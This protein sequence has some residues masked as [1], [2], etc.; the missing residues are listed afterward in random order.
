MTRDT[1][2]IDVIDDEAGEA[3]DE[4]EFA[5]WWAQLPDF[6]KPDYPFDM[7]PARLPFVQ[8]VFTQMGAPRHCPEARCRRSGQCRGGDGPPCLRA[9]PKDL[10][11]VLFLVYMMLFAD[12][13]EQELWRTL[14]AQG[15]RY[16][17]E[18]L[19]VPEELAER[20]PS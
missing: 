10:Q 7:P 9:D 17:Q 19:Q 15:N 8:S 1:D 16:A 18:P 4:A 5:E 20:S 6:I 3:I 13:P 2:A 12:W 14:K 11:Q